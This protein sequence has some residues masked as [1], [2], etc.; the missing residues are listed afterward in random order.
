MPE[1][2][3]EL[4]SDEGDGY[5]YDVTVEEESAVTEHRVTFSIEYYEEMTDAELDPEEFVKKSFEF[6]LEREPKESILGEFDLSEISEH[7]PE[8]KDEIMNE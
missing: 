3:L 7:F 5:V 1:V 6:L 2:N 8:Y 4:I